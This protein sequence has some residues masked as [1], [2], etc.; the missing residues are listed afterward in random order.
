MSYE[1]SQCG[2]TFDPFEEEAAGP[3]SDCPRCGGLAVEQ[4]GAPKPSQFEA[5]DPFAEPEGEI[6]PFGGKTGALPLSPSLF[7]NY[8]VE[9]GGPGAAPPATAPTTPFEQVEDEPLGTGD[10]HRE[11]TMLLPDEMSAPPPTRP[12]QSPARLAPREVTMPG[13]SQQK[14]QIAGADLMN[15]VPQ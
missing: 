8:F 10:I 13:L 11:P 9:A 1:C 15:P 3:F 2:Y 14:V 4:Q 7:G 12:A 5:T 6:D